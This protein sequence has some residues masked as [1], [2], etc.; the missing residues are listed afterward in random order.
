MKTII[1]SILKFAGGPRMWSFY[2]VAMD[3]LEIA[4]VM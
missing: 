3:I 4:P 1:F 2:R